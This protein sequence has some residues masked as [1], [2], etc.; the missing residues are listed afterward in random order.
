MASI[1]LTIFTR[2]NRTILICLLA[3]CW[4]L[5]AAAIAQSG[6]S[7][8]AAIVGNVR[9]EQ[10]GAL[11]GVSVTARQLESNLVRT[12]QSAADGSF[13]FVQLPPGDYE[14]EASA[15]GFTRK[16]IKLTLP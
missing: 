9:D 8:T 7:T 15:E 6:G 10:G 1:A 4:L 16:L 12:A 14:I 13:T 11:S 5:P 3:I 2:F